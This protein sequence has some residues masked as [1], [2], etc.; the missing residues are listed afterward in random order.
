[1]LAYRPHLRHIFYQGDMP[2]VAF[3][4]TFVHSGCRETGKVEA[5]LG[6]GSLLDDPMI[7]VSISTGGKNTNFAYE[8]LLRGG[9][10]LEGSNKRYPDMYLLSRIGRY[11]AGNDENL[12]G[13]EQR[14][15]A[16]QRINVVITN[17]THLV[18]QSVK[19]CLIAKL[20]S[21]TVEKDIRQQLL[22]P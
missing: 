16:Q 21:P 10:D 4:E 12:G 6:F 9:K 2:L 3:V 20:S 18:D 17:F 7:V 22:G 15:R 8:V 5:P 19:A 11:Q 13:R 1:M 14:R